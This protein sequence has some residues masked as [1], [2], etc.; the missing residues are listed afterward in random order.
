MIETRKQ[1]L[2]NFDED[3]QKKFENTLDE[4][5]KY[6][7]EYETD[8]W[9]VLNFCLKDFAI[10]NGEDYSF[11][12]IKENKYLPLGE[13]T[14]IKEASLDRNILT[15]NDNFGSKIIEEYYSK[16][17]FSSNDEMDNF[18][19]IIIPDLFLIFSSSFILY[20]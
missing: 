3:I 4:T 2:D 10:F 15:P 16:N 9:R 13:Y 7:K 8:F 5:N 17:S 19:K 18:D 20:L 6:L 14:I 1:L 11:K 12:I